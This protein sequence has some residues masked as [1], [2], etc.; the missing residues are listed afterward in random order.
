L[1]S[2]TVEPSAARSEYRKRAASYV[3]LPL[4]ASLKM[5]YRRPGRVVIGLM[6][7]VWPSS[8]NSTS[9]SVL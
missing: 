9:P 1:K 2:R 6:R 8:V 5:K 4:V 3:S 7:S